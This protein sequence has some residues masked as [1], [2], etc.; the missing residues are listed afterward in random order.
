MLFRSVRGKTAEQPAVESRTAGTNDNTTALADLT[1]EQRKIIEDRNADQEAREAAMKAA[2]AENPPRSRG[3]GKGKKKEAAPSEK[4][5]E[6]AP[7]AEAAST[8]AAAEPIP[9]AG[10]LT[11]GDFANYIDHIR[12]IDGSGDVP[13]GGAWE[14]G[15]AVPQPQ[16]E[17]APSAMDMSRL[18]ASAAPT[19]QP[20]PAPA[21]P[22]G[23]SAEDM[24]A[25]LG[26]SA[27]PQPAAKIDWT[28]LFGPAGQESRP[29]LGTPPGPDSSSR[30]P[31][32]TPQANP[33]RQMGQSDI[34][35]SGKQESP[36]PSRASQFLNAMG[37]GVL[38]GPM[39]HVGRN[40]GMYA[41]PAAVTAYNMMRSNGPNPAH[42][43]ALEQERDEAL[44]EFENSLGP[45]MPQG[46]KSQIG[47]AHV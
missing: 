31:E 5:A 43:K 42:I 7:P 32:P 3:K 35:T 38:D 28:D 26:Q 14:V 2:A 44:K 41:I 36:P 20:M 30:I 8:P 19:P 24:L 15:S 45:Q 34:P 13:G 40:W 9:G 17:P 21:M 39:R 25:L 11:R 47:R 18:G 27:S 22:N 37:L 29:D 10:G 33:W 6:T 46:Q 1:A 12:A 23:L 16:P 4:T